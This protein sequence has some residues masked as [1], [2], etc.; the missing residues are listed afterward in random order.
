V[1]QW[2][3]ETDVVV[4]GGGLAG[5]CAAFEAATAGADV[6]LFE[7]QPAV[8]GSSVLSGGFFAFAGTDM[9]KAAG[10]DDTNERL[11]DDLKKA[12]G[13][14][15][16]DRLVKIY[17]EQ[18]LAAYEWLKKIGVA[19]K[20]LQLS[21]AQSVPRTHPVDPQALLDRV[22]ALAESTGRVTTLVD[23]PVSRLVQAAPGGRVTGVLANVA[24]KPESIA[25]RR[26]VVLA[27]GG[28]SRNEEMLKQFVPHQAQGVRYGG[29]G[30]VG[31]GIKMAW[32]LGAGVRDMVFVKGTF[33]F[34]PNSR[35]EDGRDWTKL[36]VYR[37]AIAVNREA[38]R[39]VDESKSYKLLGDA[40]LQQPGGIAFQIFDQAI[41]DT[42]ADGV[43]PFDFRS[44]QR[45]GLVF[46]SATLAELATKI[47]VDAA[48]LTVTVA[49]YNEF[50][51]AGVDA[52]FGRDGLSTHYGKLVK[53]ERAPFYA[54]PSTS[55]I[56]ATYCG[57]TVDADTRV[58]NVFGEPIAGL[59]AAGELMGGFH[60]VAYMTGSSLGK[61]VIFGRIAGRNAAR[62]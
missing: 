39:Y 31:D 5:Y 16:D 55:G 52:D 54:Y 28:F 38:K 58:L 15:N 10:V 46:E 60:G 7:K 32:A 4:V 40:V 13:G 25:A 26:G 56:I 3:R 12:G 27:A 33:G 23:S 17:V 14:Q 48:Q 51:A 36:A 19:F 57:L 37:G 2:H 34:H 21:S 53:I 50:A 41:M 9:Q 24:G 6:L 1:T 44:A 62:A 20:S 22:R 47:G 18:Q 8:G 61:C 35:Q 42:A 30:N 59:Y 11:Y 45:R 49:R 29:K 43:P